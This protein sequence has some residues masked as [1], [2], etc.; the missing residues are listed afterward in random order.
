M[1]DHVHLLVEMPPTTSI[2]QLAKQVKGGSSHF[3]NHELRVEN[4]FRWQ[5][6]YGAF[7]VSH[8]D[9]PR[10]SEYVA[11]QKEHHREGDLVSGLET[12][13]PE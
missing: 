11:R 5:E 1:P 8:W 3:A 7:T 12:T 6:G 13:E 9:I 2:A 4:L 10:L